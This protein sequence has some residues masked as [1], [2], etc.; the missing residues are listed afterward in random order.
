[1][2][3]KVFVICS[4]PE[5]GFG[6]SIFGVFETRRRAENALKREGYKQSKNPEVWITRRRLSADCDLTIDE[7]GMNR[8]DVG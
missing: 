7:W 1:M 2:S 6:I 3:K 8:W 5:Y 4:L